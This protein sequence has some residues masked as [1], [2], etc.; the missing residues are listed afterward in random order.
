MNESVAET[1]KEELST[2]ILTPLFHGNNV[3]LPPGRRI[4][5]LVPGN[6]IELLS[7]IYSDLAQLGVGSDYYIQLLQ[8]VNT[9]CG[10]GKYNQPIILPG[11]ERKGE[12]LGL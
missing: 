5:T 9:L 1:I 11:K 6:D 2:H 10:G 8:T 7:S 12:P 4:D 3:I